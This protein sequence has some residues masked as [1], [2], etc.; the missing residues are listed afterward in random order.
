[1]YALYLVVR[2]P[3]MRVLDMR[4]ELGKRVAVPVNVDI[5]EIA[6]PSAGRYECRCP[7][8]TLTGSLAG[9]NGWHGFFCRSVVSARLEGETDLN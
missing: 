7:V 6:P 2:K 3:I 5:V 1:M 4:L 8:E 9:R